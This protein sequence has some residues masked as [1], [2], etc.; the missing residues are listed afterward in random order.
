MG[1]CP[2]RRNRVF[3][4]K[5]PDKI[6]YWTI[7][8]RHAVVRLQPAATE[9]VYRGKSRSQRCKPRLLDAKLGQIGGQILSLPRVA[10]RPAASVWPQETSIKTDGD[11]QGR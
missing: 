11:R 3:A 1:R 5:S 8:T 4:M 2:S 9:C 6:R 10:M 7:D